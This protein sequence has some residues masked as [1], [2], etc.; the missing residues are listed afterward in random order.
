MLR[1]LDQPSI[2]GTG[3]R[4]TFCNSRRIEKIACAVLEQNGRGGMMTWRSRVEP[5]GPDSRTHNRTSGVRNTVPY[6]VP[7]LD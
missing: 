3:F 7:T 4:I 2:A 1:L 6:F 5:G